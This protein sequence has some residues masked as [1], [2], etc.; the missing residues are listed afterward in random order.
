MIDLTQFRAGTAAGKE[1]VA[2][3]V[4]AAW[5]TVGFLVVE[6]HG[7]D[8]AEGADLHA[9]ALAFF[10]LP[11]AEKLAVRRPRNDQN[12]GYIPTA[13]K[14]W[15]ACM[16]ARRRRTIKKFSPSAPTTCQ[17]R[18]ITPGHSPIPTSRLIC[19][20]R[21]CGVRR[22]MLAYYASMVDLSRLLARI[23]AVALDLPEDFFAAK[24]TRHSS[25]LRML[26]YPVPDRPFAPG[27]LR[28]GAHSDLGMTTILRNEA[29]PGGLEVLT[30]PAI[31]WRRRPCP[32]P[33]SSTLAI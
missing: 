16:A 25:Q 23:Y 24:L 33:L 8:P 5:E 22:R 14:P 10:D 11:M 3:A 17:R 27:Q 26:H 32:T 4:A 20:R 1:A 28:C 21:R 31:G 30:P 18:P 2:R 6:G 13:K 12:R 15:R 9:S 29:A 7:V 19:G